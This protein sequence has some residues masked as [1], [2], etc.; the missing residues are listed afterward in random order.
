M[1]FFSRYLNGAVQTRFNRRTR[2]NDEYD[3][4]DAETVSLFPI[5]GC[6]IGAKKTDPFVLDNKSLRHAD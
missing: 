3:P 1:K 4:T 2:N 6:P 5:K